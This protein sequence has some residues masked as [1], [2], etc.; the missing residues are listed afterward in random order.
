VTEESEPGS[1]VRHGHISK[2]GS[3]WLR[4]VLCEAAQT[5]RH[6]PDF[7]A[8]CQ[9]ITRRRGK[10]TATTAIARKLLTRARHLLTNAKITTPQAATTT[11]R[12]RPCGALTDQDG[13]Q[14]PGQLAKP[15]EPATPHSMT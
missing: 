14:A 5:A 8:A 3:A 6:H 9:A 2:Q 10:K 11:P 13:R 1:P 15:H 7:T 4:W 12:A